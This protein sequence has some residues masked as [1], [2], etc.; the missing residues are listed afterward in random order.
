[1][2]RRSELVIVLSLTLSLVL[3]LLAACAAPR[4]AR[5]DED[6][7]A[8]QRVRFQVESAR[9]VANDWIEAVM[10]VSAEDVDP[11]ALADSV[12]RTMTWAL[13]Q[14]RQ[15]DAVEVKSGGYATHPVYQE[16]RLRRWRASQDL[17]L[18][19]GDTEAVT[20]LVGTLQ[21][22]LQLRSF[23]FRVSHETRAQVEEALV[24]EALAAF[25]ARAE[26]VRSS[27]GADGYAIDEIDV[28]AGGGPPPQPY[29]ARARVMAAEVAPPA[30]EGG[31]TRLTVTARGSIVLE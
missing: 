2:Q 19:S 8:R 11:A 25:Q 20:A 27:L 10:G 23:R 3:G 6:G 21:S 15:A 24:A 4:S 12:N 7:E 9:E 5:A 29:E 26:L 22:R 14:A 13:E 16:G 30:V 18:E 31:S 28:D 1:M 17:V